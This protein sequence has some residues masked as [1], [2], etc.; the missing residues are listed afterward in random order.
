MFRWVLMGLMLSRLGLA[1][2]Y[3][4]FVNLSA[5][6]QLE[7][8][9]RTKDPQVRLQMQEAL[10]Q[11]AKRDPLT[12]VHNRG[13]YQRF[14]RRVTDQSSRGF[15]EMGQN[16]LGMIMVDLDHFKKVNDT[17]GHEAGDAVLKAVGKAITKGTREHVF[18]QGGEEFLIVMES[19]D[20]K[21]V[22][23]VA[24][25]LRLKIEA[26]EFKEYPGLKVTASFGVAVSSADNEA[27]FLSLVKAADEALY[28]AKKTGR[29]RVIFNHSLSCQSSLVTRI[30][31]S[32]GG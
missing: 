29:N 13:S 5:R 14:M 28:I 30:K 31:R 25:R 8:L 17:L 20:V 11:A 26:L 1:E 18:R 9:A 6:E 4:W 16:G 21:I 12:G 27:R 24:E 7:T 19:V 10:N 22:R 15:S 23:R 2:D 32:S 3:E